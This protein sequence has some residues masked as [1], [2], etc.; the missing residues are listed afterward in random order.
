MN[1]GYGGCYARG[2]N[3]IGTTKTGIGPVYADKV[4][5]NG[6]RIYELKNWELFVE[7]FTFQAKIKNKILK[8]FDVEQ[9]NIKKE[10]KKFEQLRKIILPFVADTFQLLHN[11]L[12][13]N[14]K[15]LM[16]GA[17]AVLLDVDFS[18]YPFTTASNTIAGA[19]N[20][21]AGIPPHRSGWEFS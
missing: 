5:Y 13:E 21:G 8:T 19:I 9:I 16:E 18:A 11:A 2:K 20:S 12:N 10:L 14:K 4:S 6:L 3:K 1:F 15:I 17:Q 7:K